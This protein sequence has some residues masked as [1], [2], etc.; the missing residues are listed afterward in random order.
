[1]GR[2]EKQDELS[3]TDP[4]WTPALIP[5]M[6]SSSGVYYIGFG[7]RQA[8]HFLLENTLWPAAK[9]IWSEGPGGGAFNGLNVEFS[10]I[11]VGPDGIGG[12]GM[13]PIPLTF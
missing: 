1:M 7:T 2:P 6:S 4:Y 12:G 5:D 9:S 13:K 11:R 8:G 10:D 3:K